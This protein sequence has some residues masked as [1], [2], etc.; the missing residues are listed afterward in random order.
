MDDATVE[1]I[2]KEFVP[3][4]SLEWGFGEILTSRGEVVAPRLKDGDTGGPNGANNPFAPKRLHAALAKFKQL[5]PGK[6]T[7]RVEELP[8]IWKGKAE[9]PPPA[10][11]LI[12]KQYRRVIHKDGDGRLYRHDLYHDFVWMTRAEWQSLVPEQPRVGDSF[13]VPAFL[14]TRIGRHHAQIINPSA[15]VRIN[16]PPKPTLTLTV[17]DVSPEQLRLR[18]Q[19]SFQVTEYQTPLTNGVIDYQV[20][21]CLHYDV[22]KKAFRRFDMVAYGDVANL[23]KDAI[24]P[25]KGRTMAAGLLFELI[26]GTTPWERTPPYDSVSNGGKNVY[27]KVGQ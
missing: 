6:R 9:P 13:T 2:N 18:L 16:A 20:C 15:S 27:F 11:G 21:G 10:G 12:L 7:A 23:R 5:P 25:P 14:V 19:G 4:V 8:D 24:G 3:L 17:E 22:K 26:P 1:L